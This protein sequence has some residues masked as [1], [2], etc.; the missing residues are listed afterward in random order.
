MGHFNTPLSYLNRL[1]RPKINFTFKLHH[2]THG[3][4]RYL[5]NIPYSAAKFIIF[6]ESH[7]N[8]CNIDETLGI[9]ASLKKFKVYFLLIKS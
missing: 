8:F 5:H 9:K 3:L 2:I 7:G 4:D 1:C 6:S